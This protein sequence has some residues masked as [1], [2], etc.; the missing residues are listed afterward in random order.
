MV[1]TYVLASVA[2]V[3]VTFFLVFLGLEFSFRQWVLFLIVASFVIPLYVMPDIYMIGRHLR[4]ITGVLA[5][6]DRGERPASK[7]VSR[8]IVRALNLPFFS[9]VRVTLFHGPMASIGAGLGLV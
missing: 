3:A 9:F 4:P 2:A 7:D 5:V 8:A 1:G 6:V